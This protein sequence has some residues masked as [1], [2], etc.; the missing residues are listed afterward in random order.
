MFLLRWLVLIEFNWE[1]IDVLLVL[2][3]Y[4]QILRH[5]LCCFT[6]IGVFCR[7]IYKSNK[8]SSCLWEQETKPGSQGFFLR[9]CRCFR[10]NDPTPTPS[11]P[12]LRGRRPAQPQP[13]AK[14]PPRSPAWSERRS[15]SCSSGSGT[16]RSGWCGE[17]SGPDPTAEWWDTVPALTR[18]QLVLITWCWVKTIIMN[19]LYKIRVTKSFTVDLDNRSK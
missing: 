15:C 7:S 19:S 10:W 1:Y 8:R 14:L 12:S 16:A 4:Y 5:T 17:E 18:R 9:S 13:V 2:R 11:S 3:A 6:W